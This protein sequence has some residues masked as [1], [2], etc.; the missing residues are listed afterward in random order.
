ML[1]TNSCS[2]WLRAAP[3]GTSSQAFWAR[4]PPTNEVQML[5]AGRQAGRKRQLGPWAGPT[6]YACPYHNPALTVK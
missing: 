3:R 1:Y 5:A 2:H 4:N 6:H